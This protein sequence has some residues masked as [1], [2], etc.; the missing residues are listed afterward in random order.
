MKSLPPLVSSIAVLVLGA[1]SLPLLVAEDKTPAMSFDPRTRQL[2][3]L[4]VGNNAIAWRIL[5]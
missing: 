2:G 4:L 5:D 3:D 1:A